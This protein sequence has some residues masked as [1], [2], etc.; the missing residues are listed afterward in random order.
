MRGGERIVRVLA[1]VGAIALLLAV[2]GAL[3]GA[4][5]VRRGF[6]ALDEPSALEVRA[7][8]ALRSLSVPASARR[9]QNPV[10]AS[11]ETLEDARA[12]WADHCATCHANDGSGQTSLGQG[13]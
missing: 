4:I 7:A 8:R 3:Y 10:L 13:L 2:G 1:A 6:S 11:P 9:L 5:L 12:H